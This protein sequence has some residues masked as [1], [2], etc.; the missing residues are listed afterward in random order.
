[1]ISI[2]YHVY[3][4]FYVQNCAFS[5]SNPKE[6]IYYIITLYK[7]YKKLIA[8]ILLSSICVAV[9]VHSFRF[10]LQEVLFNFRGTRN[11]WIWIYN[12]CTG[13]NWSVNSHHYHHYHL[14][15]FP[16]YLYNWIDSECNVLLNWVKSDF[17]VQRILPNDN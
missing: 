17:I 15:R 3:A 6:Y 7:S 1:M 16:R 8:W 9:C 12:T 13:C 10:T 5:T 11:A 4:C 2:L 14:V